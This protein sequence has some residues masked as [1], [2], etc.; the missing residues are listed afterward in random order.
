VTPASALVSSAITDGGHQEA[1]CL[2]ACA[3]QWMV[4][5]ME[6]DP[7]A[8]AQGIGR[9]RFAWIDLHRPQTFEMAAMSTQAG[10]SSS[11]TVRHAASRRTSG[12]GS[13]LN[14]TG[15]TSYP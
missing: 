2:E 5:R 9:V 15:M 12:A 13:Q 6:D 4:A 11:Y 3:R 10:F 1:F 8:D 7:V 14:S